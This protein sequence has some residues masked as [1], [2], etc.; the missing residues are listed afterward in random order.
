MLDKLP[1]DSDD[2]ILPLERIKQLPG[3]PG[4]ERIERGP[5]VIIECD[6][7]IP[8]NPCEDIC[9]E[10]AI[11][12]G[13]PITNLPRIDPD[14]CDGCIVCISICPG[15]CMFVV[16]KNY[17]E[18]ESLI[19]LPY[20]MYPLPEK[21]SVVHGCDRRGEVVCRARVE[22]VMKARK[23]Q[24]TAVVAVAVPKTHFETVRAIRL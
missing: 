3:Y 16:H 8:C 14:K 19:Y 20:E 10:G 18:M 23:L 7:D 11:T 15:L 6:E 22:K 17:S 12:V 13:E 21:G 9:P 24:K 2:G 5:V 1:N 4:E